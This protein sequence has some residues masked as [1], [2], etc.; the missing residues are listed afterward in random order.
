MV[1]A[2]EGWAEKLLVGVGGKQIRR[3]V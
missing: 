3:A 2:V 1:L